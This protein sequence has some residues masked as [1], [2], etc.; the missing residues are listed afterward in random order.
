MFGFVIKNSIHRHVSATLWLIRDRS[1]ISS[2]GNRRIRPKH[3]LIPSH[4]WISHLS[5]LGSEPEQWWETAISQWQRLRPSI[6]Q[7]M[8]PLGGERASSLWQRLR[9][10]GYQWKES[11]NSQRQCLRPFS[12]QGN[13]RRICIWIKYNKFKVQVHHLKDVWIGVKLVFWVWIL[14]MIGKM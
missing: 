7:G 12:H 8:P 11:V 5:W 6:Y 14:S 9:P 1:V 3:C 4:C 10:L 2:G 13:L